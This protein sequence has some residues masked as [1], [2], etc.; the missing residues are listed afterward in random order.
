MAR[1]DYKALPSEIT[2]EGLASALSRFTDAS[3]RL[4][5][6]Y[7]A[8]RGE[9]EGLRAQLREKELEIRRNERLSLLGETAAALAHEIRNPLGAVRLLTS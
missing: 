6:R 8:L 4:E 9:V 1:M 3:E 2:G 5:L 7:Q